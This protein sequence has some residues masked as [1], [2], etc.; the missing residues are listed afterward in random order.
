MNNTY[1]MAN[2]WQRGN[3]L[4]SP[5]FINFVRIQRHLKISQIA[6]VSYSLRGWVERRYIHP[7]NLLEDLCLGWLGGIQSHLTG[8]DKSAKLAHLPLGV[9]GAIFPPSWVLIHLGVGG[10]PRQ[11]IM[12]AL[13]CL[14]NHPWRQMANVIRVI[15]LSFV[16]YGLGSG[17]LVVFCQSPTSA[18]IKE[19]IHFVSV[20]LGGQ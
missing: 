2:Y 19:S 5:N 20:R 13:V 14:P 8:S 6:N 7:L 17:V 1:W 11:Y 15:E 12:Y 10:K 16:G 4:A 18:Y 3:S 9:V